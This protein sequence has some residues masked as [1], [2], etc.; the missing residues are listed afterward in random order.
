MPL[1]WITK[2]TDPIRIVKNPHA[3]QASG[4]RVQGSGFRVQGSGFRVQGFRVQGLR[5]ARSSVEISFDCTIDENVD[6]L[7]TLVNLG[8]YDSG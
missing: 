4:F 1:R 7:C 8:I 3:V 2:T 6:Y 5:P